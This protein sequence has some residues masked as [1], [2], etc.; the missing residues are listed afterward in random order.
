MIT[1]QENRND[2]T[3]SVEIDLKEITKQDIVSMINEIDPEYDI[4]KLK[5]G[6]KLVYKTEV[7]IPK[8]INNNKINLLLVFGN[9]AIHSVAERMFFSYERT[10]N[11]NKFKEH[12]F[13]K[14]SRCCDILKFNR[15]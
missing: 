14:A 11:K 7:L 15:D 2:I 8:T 3:Q 9:P 13:W 10:Q 12:R 4:F 6:N 5:T 1:Y